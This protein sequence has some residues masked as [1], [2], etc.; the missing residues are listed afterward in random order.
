MASGGYRKPTS[1]APTSG[2]GAMSRRTDGGP[3][4]K[5]RYMSGGDYGDGQD[6]MDLQQSATMAAAPETSR[7]SRSRSRQSPP[8]QPPS[9]TDPTDRPN[10]PLTAGADFGP[11]AGSEVLANGSNDPAAIRDAD[12][13]R[14]K[15]HLPSLMRMAN[16]DAPEGFK[17]FVRF[18]RDMS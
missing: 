18:L 13:Q 7:P 6:M 2:P 9:L 17:R 8:P 14:I 10:E 1:P 3:G 5:P 11:G 16:T 15:D 12:M 4:Q